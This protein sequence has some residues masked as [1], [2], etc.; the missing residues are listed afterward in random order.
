MSCRANE[1]RPGEGGPLRVAA[2]VS[3]PNLMSLPLLPPFFLPEGFHS[4]VPHQD[5]VGQQGMGSLQKP[6]SQFVGQILGS[7][8]V[9]R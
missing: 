4:L 2:C 9:G 6:F 8:T 1:Q 5:Q 7:R 3:L